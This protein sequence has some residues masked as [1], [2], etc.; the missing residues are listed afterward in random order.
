MSLFSLQPIASSCRASF[1]YAVCLFWPYSVSL[2][3]HVKHKSSHDDLLFRWLCIACIV[4][5][6]VLVPL[7][8]VKGDNTD[9]LIA[10]LSILRGV[11]ITIKSIKLPLLIRQFLTPWILNHYHRYCQVSGDDIDVHPVNSYMLVTIVMIS[12]RLFP[13]VL[14]IP[15]FAC[16]VGENIILCDHQQNKCSCKRKWNALCIFIHSCWLWFPVSRKPYEKCISPCR[17]RD[18]SQEGRSIT[19]KQCAN[20][21]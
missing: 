21:F 2:G 20:P 15:L 1:S 17:T 9:R 13:A 7:P 6:W 11:T 8:F 10:E 14:I 18:L 5:A 12:G 16:T 3:L 19:N 4:R